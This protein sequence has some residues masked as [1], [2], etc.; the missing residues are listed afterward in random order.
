LQEN[1]LHDFFG[2]S[3]LLDDAEDQAINQARVA[4]IELFEGGHIPLQKAAHQRG[5]VRRFVVLLWYEGS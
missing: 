4:V 1:V 2:G 5:V 3:G